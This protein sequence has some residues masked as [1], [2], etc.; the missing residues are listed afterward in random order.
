M[1][2]SD[3]ITEESLR[4]NNFP[5]IDSIAGHYVLNC[6][7][8][9]DLLFFPKDRTLRLYASNLNAD[10]VTKSLGGCAPVMTDPT[11]ND[12]IAL[13]EALK[14]PLDLRKAVNV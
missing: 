1:K 11:W 3:P 14:L 9:F 8:W 4:A 13:S 7:E 6:N 12:A 5:R 10:G 2:H